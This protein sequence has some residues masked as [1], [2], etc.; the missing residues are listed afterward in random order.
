MT[1]DASSA[2]FNLEIL[3]SLSENSIREIGESWSGFCS[4]AEAL[5]KVKGDLSSSSEFVSHA[6][7]LSKHGLESLVQQH[8]LGLI[9]VFFFQVTFS[10]GAADNYI[11]IYIILFIC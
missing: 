10:L 3:D 1:V 4:S 9:E 7:I 2:F 6:Q 8:F 11:Y 5:L